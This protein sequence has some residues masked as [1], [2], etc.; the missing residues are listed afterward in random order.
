MNFSVDSQQ[1]LGVKFTTVEP[2]LEWVDMEGKTL[3]ADLDFWCR[4][5]FGAAG[6]VW[7]STSPARWYYNG[8]KFWFKSEKDA[9]MFILRWS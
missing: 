9:I 1:W 3:W 6:D 8:S 4:G 2:I 5:T 7:D